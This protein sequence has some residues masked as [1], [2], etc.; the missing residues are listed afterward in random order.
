[1]KADYVPIFPLPLSQFQVLLV[2]SFILKGLTESCF[3]F[4][5]A[6]F[7]LRGSCVNLFPIIKIL[8]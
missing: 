6:A 8:F 3:N 2:F 7:Q 5:F 1:M 4:S